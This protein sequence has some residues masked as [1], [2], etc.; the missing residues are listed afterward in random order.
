MSTTVT[1]KPHCALF[2]L[3]SVAVQVTGVT[4]LSNEDPEGGAQAY[5][6]PGQLSATVAVKFTT[7]PHD[8]GSAE[9][10]MSPAQEIEGGSTSRTVTVKL[11][12]AVLPLASIAVQ[13]TGV[14]P[15]GNAEPEA[16]AQ[17]TLTPGQLS[18]ALALQVTFAFSQSPG[19]AATVKS[20]GQAIAGG[21]WSA[22][23]P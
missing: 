9:A 16:G 4:P 12:A 5:A 15:F 11:H 13:E 6:A 2:P 10:V 18:V 3:A 19:S 20:P 21:V 22:T 7:A 23:V 1:L 8:P 14:A 17:T